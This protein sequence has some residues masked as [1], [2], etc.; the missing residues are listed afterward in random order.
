MANFYCEYCG[1][2]HSSISIMSQENCMLH[3]NGTYRGGHKLYEGRE[4]SQYTCKYCG[5][6]KSSISILVQETCMRHPN[7][8]RKGR[9][10]PAL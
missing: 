10:S 1:K 3:P 8:N 4:K 5:V 2:K 9:H 6:K 7:G